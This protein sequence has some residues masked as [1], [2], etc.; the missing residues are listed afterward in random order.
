MKKYTG[1]KYWEE[2][3][4]ELVEFGDGKRFMRCYDKAGKLQLGNIVYTQNGPVYV[5]K[6]VIDRSE[7][8]NSKEGEPY[9]EQTLVDWKEGYGG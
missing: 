9:L 7:L 5:T 3:Q 8:L 1:D 2:E 4:G 6:F